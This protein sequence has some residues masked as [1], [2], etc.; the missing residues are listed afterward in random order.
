MPL[1]E[2]EQRIL[3]EIE[4]AFYKHDPQFAAKV[5]SE[6]VYRHSGRHVWWSLLGFVAGLALLLATFTTSLVLG[7]VGFAV[8]L[9]SLLVMERNLR[10]MGRAGLSELAGAGGNGR[11]AKVWG[12]VSERT[13]RRF[14]RP[15]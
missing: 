4:Q 8:M 14:Q 13:R 6:T 9:A 15:E 11:I 5:K 7:L 3:Q 10:R 1:S 2:H 12:S